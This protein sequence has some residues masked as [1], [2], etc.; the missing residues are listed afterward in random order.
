[1][2]GL[3]EKYNTAMRMITHDLGIV[4]EICDKVSVIYAG[5][6]IEHGT[7]E[8]IFRNTRHPCTEGLFNSL[9]NLED[10]QAELKPIKGPMPDPSNLPKGCAFCP[11]CDYAMD[12]CKTEKPGR[13][14][15]N[16]THYVECHLYSK[17]NI[18]EGR[19]KSRCVHSRCLTSMMSPSQSKRVKR[20]ASSASPAAENPRR[21]AQSCVFSSPPPARYCSRARMW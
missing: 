17:D 19:V 12:I 11:R 18:Q 5:H 21:G 9:P 10:R 15:R 16:D 8:D 20:S 2:E 6:V 1:M 4:A 13:T 7:L 14:Y 3:R